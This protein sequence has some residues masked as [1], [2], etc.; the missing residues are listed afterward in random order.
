VTCDPGNAASAHVIEANGGVEEP[1][2]TGV[3]RFWIS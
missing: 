3:R 1:G 2:T